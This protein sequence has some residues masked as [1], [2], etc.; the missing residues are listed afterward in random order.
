MDLI[1]T[2]LKE[3]EIGFKEFFPMLYGVASSVLAIMVY[4]S[5]HDPFPR[6]S[7]DFGISQIMFF[8]NLSTKVTG[9][10]EFLVKLSVFS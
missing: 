2:T 9:N 1:I 3:C 6:Q 4:N 5:S 8:P 10:L 7:R